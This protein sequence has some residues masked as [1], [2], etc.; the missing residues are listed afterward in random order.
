MKNIFDISV[1]IGSDDFLLFKGIVDIG[2]DS[3]LTGFTE[4][5]FHYEGDRFFFD[6][7]FGELEILIRR[8]IE[9]ETNTDLACQ[10]VDD[11]ILFAYGYEP[12]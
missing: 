2:I 1:C 8:L 3:R 10:W 5:N 9:L 4:S 7:A 6:F 11:I 12:E